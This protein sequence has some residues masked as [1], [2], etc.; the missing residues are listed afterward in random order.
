MLPL[1]VSEC[2][3]RLDATRR[4]TEAA[5]IEVL[6]SADPANMTLHL[7]PAIWTED[8]GVEISEFSG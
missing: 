7:V 3:G 6:I 4:R 2:Q 8:W 5:G 1:E